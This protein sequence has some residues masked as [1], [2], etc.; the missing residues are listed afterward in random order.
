[1][2][3]SKSKGRRCPKKPPLHVI[4][5]LIMPSEILPWEQDLLAVVLEAVEGSEPG[6]QESTTEVSS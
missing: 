3:K 5:P 1:M 4:G 6:M 2:E